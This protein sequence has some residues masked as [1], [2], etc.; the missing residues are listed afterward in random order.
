MSDFKINI[1]IMVTNLVWWLL[2][3]TLNIPILTKYSPVE[4]LARMH[5]GFYSFVFF[6]VFNSSFH[7]RKFKGTFKSSN[8]FLK[9][10]SFILY[11]CK[12]LALPYLLN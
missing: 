7:G 2:N 5:K 11:F 6:I 10:F 9:F 12:Y 3:S 1:S 4:Q 8:N